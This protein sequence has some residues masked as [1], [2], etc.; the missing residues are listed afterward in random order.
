[1]K[2][3]LEELLPVLEDVLA[4]G[5]EVSLTPNGVSMRPMLE[6]GRDTITL[7]RFNR[8]LK[9]YALPL[10]RN[11]DG[12]FILH[13]VI[14]KNKQGYIMRGDNLLIKEYGITDDMILGE[15]VSFVRKGKEHSVDEPLYKLYCIARNNGVTVFLRKIKLIL[16]RI[17]YKTRRSVR[18]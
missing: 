9:K 2:V 4:G 6:S 12:R 18:K 13:R 10:Y 7:K 11:K 8:P 14:G 5:G 3:T 17:A 16:R 15:V 1:M